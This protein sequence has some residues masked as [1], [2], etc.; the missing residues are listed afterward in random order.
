MIAYYEVKEL[1]NICCLRLLIIHVEF[2]SSLHACY[3][4]NI[5]LAFRC[6]LL[7]IPDIGV[8]ALELTAPRPS[9]AILCSCLTLNRWRIVGSLL[10]SGYSEA[11]AH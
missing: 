4:D 9:S 2:I 10:A 8:P 5:F 7:L 11:P 3:P 6:Q 1:A